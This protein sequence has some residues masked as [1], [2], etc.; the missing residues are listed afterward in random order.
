M[1]KISCVIEKVKQVAQFILKASLS[2]FLYWVNPSLFAI[3]FIAGIVI[4]DQVRCAIQKIKAVWKNQKITGTLLGGFACAL[5]LPV[6]LATASILWSA[7]LGSLVTAEAQKRF[8]YPSADEKTQ[9]LPA[10]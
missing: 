4:D 7:H 3:G 9:M 2:A 8:N 5:S 10:I 1:N 6:S